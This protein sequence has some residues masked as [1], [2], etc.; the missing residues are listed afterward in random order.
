[1]KRILEFIL[2]IIMPVVVG[3]GIYSLLQWILTGT[4]VFFGGLYGTS[5]SISTIEVALSAT[6]VI[7]IVALG[8]YAWNDIKK[9]YKEY[10]NRLV[11]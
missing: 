9:V 4:F 3:L 8:M 2:D 6:D 10:K 1:M 5:T 7:V 11:A